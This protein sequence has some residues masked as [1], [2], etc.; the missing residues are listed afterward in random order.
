MGGQQQA[1]T[2]RALLTHLMTGSTVPV[3]GL[4]PEA[5][6]HARRLTLDLRAMWADSTTAGRRRLWQRVAN[7]AKTHG[8]GMADATC[9]MWIAQ[10]GVSVQTKLAYAK[11]LRAML[12]RMDEPTAILGM[13][14]A[15]YSASGGVVPIK[16]A[17]PLTKD[18]LQHIIARISHP[19]IRAA[20][21]IAWKTA[22]RFGEVSALKGINFVRLTQT[23]III[24]W[25]ALPKTRKR[26][27]YV[28]SRYAV[29]E[30]DWT[31]LIFLE[32]Q[33]IRAD[34]LLTDMTTAAVDR[35]IF[36]ETP[37]TCHSLKHGALNALAQAA[38]AGQVD[39]VKISLLAK[40]KSTTELVGTTVRYVQDRASAA[41]ML[42]TQA[43][44]TLL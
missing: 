3:A 16:Q 5:Q 7:Y 11:T 19:R 15:S 41:L 33:G 38:A 24:D 13:A 10:L 40:H 4:S 28:A 25:G 8:L 29:I 26:N 2:A 37:F 43:A 39:P 30:G 9:A 23:Q 21:R 18:A 14:A 27:P 34:E 44:T 20:L 1:F 6:S 32:T 35:T 36:R 17:N 22:S 31:Y 42:G 12:R